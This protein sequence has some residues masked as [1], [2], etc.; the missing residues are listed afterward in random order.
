MMKMNCLSPGALRR[1]FTQQYKRNCAPE[2]PHILAS[3]SPALWRMGSDVL[4]DG[5]FREGNAG[6][7]ENA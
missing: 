5:S 4:P 1:F 6:G 2:S 7:T 3:I